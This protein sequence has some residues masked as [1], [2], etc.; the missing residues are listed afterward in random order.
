[1]RNLFVL[2]PALLGACS[3]VAASGPAPAPRSLPV[4]GETPG[5]ACTVE[6]TQQFVGQ[7]RSDETAEAIK[8]VSH[9]RIVRW[10]PPGVAMT[11]DFRSDRVTVYL[12]ASNTITKINC[13]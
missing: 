10:A 2:F 4:H 7:T 9:A 6:G 8:R 1:M 12:D 11:M 13:G 5:H 3:S